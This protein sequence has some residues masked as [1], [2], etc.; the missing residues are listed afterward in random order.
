MAI[1]TLL[2]ALLATQANAAN[3]IQR[4]AFPS[5]EGGKAFPLQMKPG[6]KTLLIY[7]LADCPIARKFSPEINR[8]V[9][10]YAAKGVD[11]YLVQ[12][13]PSATVAR[14]QAHLKE[15]GIKCPEV[16]DRRHDLVSF[17]GVKT[18]PTA[19]VVDDR[20]RVIYKGRIDDRFPALGV[21]RAPRRRDLRIALDE[22]LAGKPISVARTQAVGCMVPMTRRM[23]E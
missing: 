5:T 14:A 22:A 20:L 8:I 19:A 12:V 10:E 3:P 9:T 17:A 18:V 1:T 2:A 13:D 4:M 23:E 21:Q 6:E 7:V 16:L 15:F 11:C